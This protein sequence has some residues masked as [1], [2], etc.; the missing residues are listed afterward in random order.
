M[1]VNNYVS[2]NCKVYVNYL[3]HAQQKM[4]PLDMQTQRLRLYI[5]GIIHFTHYANTKLERKA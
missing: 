2:C 3:P 5:S 1:V 4:D